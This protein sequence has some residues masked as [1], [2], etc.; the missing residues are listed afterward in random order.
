MTPWISIHPDDIAWL[1]IDTQG[2]ERSVLAGAERSLNR[3]LA[4]E[5]EL[6]YVPLYEDQ[7]LAWEIHDT[8]SNLGFVLVAFGT[9]FSG[10]RGRWPIALHGFFLMPS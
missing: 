10:N 7:A 9:P 2:S 4:V 6:T 3:A 1:K 8:L 5:I